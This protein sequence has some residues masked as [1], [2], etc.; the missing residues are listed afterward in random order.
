MA[1]YLF[2]Q[3]DVA[4]TETEKKPL[5]VGLSQSLLCGSHRHWISGVNVCNP[6]GNDYSASGTEK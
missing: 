6:C 3:G 4:D 5:W 1:S 2:H